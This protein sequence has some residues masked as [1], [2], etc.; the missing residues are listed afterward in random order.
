MKRLAR[1]SNLR[2]WTHW[3]FSLALMGQTAVANAFPNHGD[4]LPPD[5][6]PDS[7][8]VVRSWGNASPMSINQPVTD[9]RKQIDAG[10]I[11]FN[12]DTYL[13][14]NDGIADAGAALSGGFFMNEGITL[15]PGY[16]L[17]WVQTVLT[18]ITGGN[19]WNLPAENAGEFPDATP[20]DRTIPNPNTFNDQG[21]APSY[22][23][24]TPTVHPQGQNPN[25]GGGLG[26]QDFPGRRF[27]DGN[28]RWVAELALTCISDEP[29]QIVDG[30]HYRT[31]RVISSLL[32]GFRFTGLPTANPGLANVSPVGPG[33]WG[34]PSN[35]Y[36]N[37][38]NAYYDGLGGGNVVSDR[39]RFESNSNCFTH[40]PEPA[41]A[42]LL[43]FGS[44]AAMHRN[45]LRHPRSLASSRADERECRRIAQIHHRK[46][47]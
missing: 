14:I 25:T 29:N 33:D 27:A 21:M 22:R 42:L 35:T 5:G 23:F 24:N 36:L 8:F 15:K 41:T 10:R 34:A 1:S 11:R 26:F 13:R 9:T 32:W 40:I 16:K 39:Y 19:H 43:L 18:R 3:L 17:G 45:R 47:T 2:K 28:Q 4:F 30:H 46:A 7:G 20:R 44:V 37:T 31:V 6:G 12:F 38:L